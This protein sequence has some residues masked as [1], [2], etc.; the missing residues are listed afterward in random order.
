MGRYGKYENKSFI[1]VEWPTYKVDEIIER[2]LEKKERVK[3]ICISMV[4]NIRAKNDIVKITG[5]I[6]NRVDIPISLLIAPT[7]L[8]KD[9]LKAFKDS[10]ADRIGI[11]ID[12]ATPML[13]ER[14]RGKYVKGPHRWDR[15]WECFDMAVEIF[16]ERMVGSHLIVGLGETEKEMVATIQKVYDIGG[17]THLFSF[18]PEKDSMLSNFPQPPIGQYRRVQIA[19]YLIDEGISSFWKMGF[20]EDE[21]V[22]DFGLPVDK[23]S[24]IIDSGIPFMT[25]GCPGNDGQ[26]AC[27]RPYANE[28]PGDEIRNFPFKP[29]K[30]DILRIK[31][32][33]WQGG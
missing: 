15:Y 1:R 28:I 25:A 27:N 20:D 31:E 18:F 11:S 10:G 8:N 23:L 2:I 14:L 22:R 16:G 9:D 19:R 13:F 12:A 29:E 5:I 6:K 7:I 4:T 33:L 26:V 30:D 17:L 32:E 24:R 3:R 21:R